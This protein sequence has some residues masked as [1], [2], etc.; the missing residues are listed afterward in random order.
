[1]SALPSIIVVKS[2][3][4]LKR[5]L[6]INQRRTGNYLDFF[7]FCPSTKSLLKTCGIKSLGSAP[8]TRE[9]QEEILRDYIDAVG[10]LGEWNGHIPHWWMTDIASKNAYC[11]PLLLPLREFTRGIDAI[12]RMKNT[13][14]FLFLLNPSWPTVMGL[15]HVACL[16]GLNFKI[17]SWPWSKIFR[18]LLGK[19][20]AWVGILKSIVVIFLDIGRTI[21]S[22]GGKVPSSKDNKTVYLIKSFVYRDSFRNDGSYQDPFFGNLSEYISE[23]LGPKNNVATI[24]SG[25]GDKKRLYGKMKH[26]RKQVAFPFESMLRY[27]DV[28]KHVCLLSFFLIAKPFKVKGPVVFLGYDI[29]TLLRESLSSGGW[30]VPFD[31]YI[32]YA[33]G[34]RLAALYSMTVCAMTCEGNPWERAFISG[35]R[36]VNPEARIIGYQHSVIPQAAANMFQS[37]RELKRNPLPD[38]ILTTGKTPADILR[39]HSAFPGKR[40]YISS[41]LRY[42]YLDAIEPGEKKRAVNGNERILVALCGVMDTLPLARYAIKQALANPALKILARAH[43]ALPFDRLKPFI[44]KNGA[45]PENMEISFSSTLK[46]DILE[47]D[48]ILYWG[49]SVAL[50]GIR[51]GKP[52]IHFN[53]DDFLSYDPLFELKEFK[54]TIKDNEDITDVMNQIHMIP[55]KEFQNL[56]SRARRYVMSYHNPVTQDSLRHFMMY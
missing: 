46:E 5:F 54:W 1:M 36:S 28:I 12:L 33:A 21:K 42:S 40:I 45:V 41:A 22:F 9:R 35:I 24:G 3:F 56:R 14:G 49:S 32:Y 2:L 34:K 31:Q 39:K 7:V 37:S 23:H 50:E 18:K 47:C 15:R 43:P 17:L 52:A 19:A 53:Q 27:S 48:A 8:L 10:K 20:K 13:D 44:E 4:F 11:S 6:K 16:H 25:I 51:L 38:A 55:D 26:L 29:A 30:R